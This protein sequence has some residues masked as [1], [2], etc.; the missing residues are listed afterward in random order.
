[1]LQNGAAPTQVYNQQ[2]SSFNLPPPPSQTQRN[3]IPPVID[4][5]GFHSAA[6]SV[7]GQSSPEVQWSSS[8]ASSLKENA[9]MVSEN[10]GAFDVFNTNFAK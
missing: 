2:A 9:P 3:H 1:M 5:N 6:S 7:N 4:T 10:N 8:S